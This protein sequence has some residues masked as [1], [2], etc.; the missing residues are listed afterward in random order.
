MKRASLM[1]LAGTFATH[2]NRIDA[3]D[4]SYQGLL[5][6]VHAPAT[7]DGRPFALTSAAF[8]TTKGIELQSKYAVDYI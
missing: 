4:A 1:R 8:L 2:R 7:T 5:L 6:C 3:V